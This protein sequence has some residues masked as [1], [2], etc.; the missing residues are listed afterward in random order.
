MNS[1]EIVRTQIAFEVFM[2]AAINLNAESLRR[3]VAISEDRLAQI[4]APVAGL[5][6]RQFN[7]VADIM[8][9]TIF[10]LEEL[11]KMRNHAR[12]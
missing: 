5:S 2:A 3:V 12:H 8:K 11:E 6:L 9:L 4:A 1:S 10:F 7:A